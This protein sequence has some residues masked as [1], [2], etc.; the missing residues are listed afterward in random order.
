[1]QILASC[2]AIWDHAVS[3]ITNKSL[4]AWMTGLPGLPYAMTRACYDLARLRGNG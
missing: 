2:L 3:G 1:V 4:C